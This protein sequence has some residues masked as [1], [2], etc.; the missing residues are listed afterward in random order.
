MKRNIA[1]VQ[2]DHVFEVSGPI[3]VFEG[4]KIMLKE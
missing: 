3:E 2:T 4:D 1:E